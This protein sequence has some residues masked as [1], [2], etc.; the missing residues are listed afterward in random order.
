MD[1]H[2]L[3]TVSSLCFEAVT[4]LLVVLYG[5]IWSAL[6]CSTSQAH[7]IISGL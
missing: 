5:N 7:K 2:L 1:L 6:F 4:E 3:L